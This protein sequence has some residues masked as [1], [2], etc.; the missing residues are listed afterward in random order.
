MNA[1]VNIKLQ[2]GDWQKL[3]FDVI[4]RIGELIFFDDIEFEV[5]AVVYDTYDNDVKIYAK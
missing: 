5:Y 1:I 4:P 3:E 2:S